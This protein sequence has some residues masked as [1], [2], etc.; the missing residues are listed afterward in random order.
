MCPRL[1]ASCPVGLLA[2]SAHFLKKV[3]DLTP[4]SDLTGLVHGVLQLQHLDC[5]E[6]DNA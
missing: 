6:T 1:F 2:H 3:V 5:S 4:N